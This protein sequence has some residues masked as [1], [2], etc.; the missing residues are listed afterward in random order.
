MCSAARMLRHA[1]TINAVCALEKCL[2]E[3]N[4][5]VG[6]GGKARQASQ[7]FP[8]LPFDGKG[9]AAKRRHDRAST[10]PAPP[11][12]CAARKPRA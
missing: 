7:A 4:S 9:A 11:C 3:M 1:T 12:N 6:T 2:Q 5:T 10:L 8:L